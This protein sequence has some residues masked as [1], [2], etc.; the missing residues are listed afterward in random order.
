MSLSLSYINNIVASNSTFNFAID[1]LKFSE[2][3]EINFVTHAHRDHI[4]MTKKSKEMNFIM[5]PAT[6]E[7]NNTFTDLNGNVLTRDIC[8]SETYIKPLK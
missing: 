8:N 4:N 5:T 3:R 7:E 1:P 2:T 6:Q